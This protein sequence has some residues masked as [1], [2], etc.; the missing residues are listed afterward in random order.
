[1]VARGRDNGLYVNRFVFGLVR[2]H[3]SLGGVSHRRSGVSSPTPTGYSVFIRGA[4][5]AIYYCRIPNTGAPQSFV[6]ARRRCVV[7]PGR[8]VDASGMHV[9]V[10]GN[11]NAIWHRTPTT[12]WASLGGGASADPVAVADAVGGDTHVLVR[13]NDGSIYQTMLS[14][15]GWRS[16]MGGGTPV[17]AGV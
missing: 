10:R 4:D 5:G 3:R 2:I 7:R 1:M 14:G 15:G 8:R 13:G 12:P 16:L 17:R 9:I 6:S 11:D